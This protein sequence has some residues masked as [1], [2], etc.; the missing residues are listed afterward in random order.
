MIK[1]IIKLIVKINYFILN[2][3]LIFF[4]FNKY[5]YYFFFLSEYLC[6]FKCN[7]FV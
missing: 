6:I 4:H 7:L 3:I 2:L 5:I 1:F